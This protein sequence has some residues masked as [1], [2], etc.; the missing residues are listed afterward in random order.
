MEMGTTRTC[1][2]VCVCVCR[3]G[4]SHQNKRGNL[5]D[6]M[7]KLRLSHLKL[8]GAVASKQI[9]AF[10]L[11]MTRFPTYKNGDLREKPT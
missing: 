10:S 11:K 3:L 7:S 2:C 1:V 4:I 6:L 8:S 9:L 5:I